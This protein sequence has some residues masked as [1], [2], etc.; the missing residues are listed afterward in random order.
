MYKALNNVTRVLALAVTFSVSVHS[1]QAKPCDELK[2]EIADKLDAKGVKGYTLDIV[3]KADVKEGATVVGSCEA[4][5][6]KI[7]YTRGK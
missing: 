1:A 3:G 7:V 6:K 5:S 2:K 4:G